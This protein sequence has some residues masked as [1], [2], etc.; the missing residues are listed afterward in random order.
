MNYVTIAS[1]GD[2]VDF[3]DLVDKQENGGGGLGTNTR[4]IFSYGDAPGSYGDHWCFVQIMTTGNAVKG[5]DLAQ[6]RF[7]Q[8]GTSNAHGG[9]YCQILE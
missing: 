1:Q 5:G 6:S 4:G 9:L 2:A 7:G 3:G 8:R